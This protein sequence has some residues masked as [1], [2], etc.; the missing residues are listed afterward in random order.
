MGSVVEA[1]EEEGRAIRR[2]ASAARSVI[3]VVKDR[4][5]LICK[6]VHFADVQRREKEGE[7]VRDEV[8]R[9]RKT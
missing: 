6:E 9:E 2:I 3:S 7:G 4:M 5:D 1:E 8:R